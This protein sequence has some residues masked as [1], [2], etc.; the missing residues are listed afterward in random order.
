L[1]PEQEEAVPEA[2]A[3]WEESVKTDPVVGQV[4]EV[5]ASARQDGGVGALPPPPPPFSSHERRATGIVSSGFDLSHSGRVDLS[6]ARS[7]TI[8]IPT[9]RSGAV[10]HAPALPPPFG[11]LDD[12]RT[13][14]YRALF[15]EY[16][17]LRRTT[18]EPLEEVDM[19]VF[20]DTLKEKRLQ[21][22]RDLAVP[23]VRF[24]LAFDNGK[25]A[26]RY[27]VLGAPK[28]EG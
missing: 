28:R 6:L 22:V 11:T 14:E 18:G 5:E 16:L 19:N 23:D 12:P 17:R 3:E 2:E 27:V 26:I 10:R 8:A 24:R 13:E 4:P 15:T 21:L 25:A 1:T 20:V 9:E 7:G